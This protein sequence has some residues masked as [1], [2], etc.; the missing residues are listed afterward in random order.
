MHDL[1]AFV[2][3]AAN[4]AFLHRKVLGDGLI[5]WSWR[6]R[7]SSGPGWEFVIARGDEVLRQGWSLGTSRHGLEDDI[8]TA[9]L[10]LLDVSWPMGARGAA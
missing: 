5:A 1:R 8:R 3:Q 10:A 7:G 9:V 2:A 4:G 6:T